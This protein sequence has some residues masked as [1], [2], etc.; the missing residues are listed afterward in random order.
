MAKTYTQR[1]PEARD[2][3]ESDDYNP[4]ARGIMAQFNGNMGSQQAPYNAFTEDKFSDGD[5]LDASLV[6]T[7]AGA[8]A[9]TGQRFPSQTYA[10]VSSTISGFSYGDTSTLLGSPAATYNNATNYWPPGFIALSDK[11]A[12]GVYMRV[13]CKGGVLKGCALVDVQYYLGD[14][15]NYTGGTAGDIIGTSWRIEVA[16]FVDNIKVARTGIQP[17]KRHTYCLP[18]AIPVPSRDVVVDVRWAATYDGQGGAGKYEKVA[19]TSVQFFNTTLWCRN[20]YR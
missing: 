2:F 9:G 6:T 12:A 15:G 11:I 10:R 17:C 5:N 8:N 16:I 14:D 18:F 7:P 20:V 3:I 1:K 19:D 13:P 4:D